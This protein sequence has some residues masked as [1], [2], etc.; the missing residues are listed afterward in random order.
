MRTIK[1]L[2]IAVAPGFIF[3]VCAAQDLTV[4]ASSSYSIPS[5]KSAGGAATYVWLENGVEIA[6]ATGESYTNTKGNVAGTYLYT[7]MV[8]TPN[9][10]WQSS[11]SVIVWVVGMKTPPPLTAPQNACEGE[12]IELSVPATPGTT[13]S[14]NVNNIFQNEGNTCTIASATAGKILVMVS[15][16]AVAAGLHCT[17]SSA[18]AV[19][20][21]HAMP[22]IKTHPV[23]KDA[24]LDGT[25]QLSVS[26]DNATAYQWFKNGVAVTEGTGHNTAKY[27]TVALKSDATYK[28]VVSNAG[29]CSATSNEAKLTVKSCCNSPGSTAT[30]TTFKPCEP[31][32]KN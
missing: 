10:D 25:E 31:V 32:T 14:W 29:A 28:V 12:K 16:S 22:K 8:K 19:I 9:C 7:R 3:S 11:N 5:I 26:A 2:L 17:Q 20:D 15:V 18:V 24:C 1:K 30:F 27:T 4:C 6:G 21:V 23:S 13:F